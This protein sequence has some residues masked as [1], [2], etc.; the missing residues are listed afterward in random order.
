MSEGEKMIWASA[1]VVS[2]FE[3]RDRSRATFKAYEAVMAFNYEVQK[4]SDL[5][6]GNYKDYL[7]AMGKP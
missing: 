6:P 2:Y 1:F 7:L 5:K 3:E 4:A